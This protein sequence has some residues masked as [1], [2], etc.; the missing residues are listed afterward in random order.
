MLYVILFVS[1]CTITLLHYFKI[2][3]SEECKMM[4]YIV[5]LDLGCN[6]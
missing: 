6:L 4:I 3:L 2:S 1:V 5:Y